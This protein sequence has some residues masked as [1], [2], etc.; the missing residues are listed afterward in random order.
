MPAARWPLVNDRPTIWVEL[1]ALHRG[2]GLDRCL[3]AD[4]G[5]GD[6]QSVFQLVLDEDDCVHCGGISIGLVQLGGAYSGSFPLYL[7]NV[8]IAVLSFSQPVPVVGVSQPPQGF[9]GIA[10]FGFLNR[11]HYG[12]FGYPGYFGI[13]TLV[14]P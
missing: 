9:G 14:V 1:S 8:R 13:D 5:A 10:G 4:T 6:R 7:L 3:V 12:N 11:F 2:S